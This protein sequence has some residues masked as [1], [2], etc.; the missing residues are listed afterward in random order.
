VVF[1]VHEALIDLG[2]GQFRKA[3][4]NDGINALSVLQETNDIVDTDAGSLHHGMAAPNLR[5]PCDVPIL[6]RSSNHDALMVGEVP[7]QFK[8]T[9]DSWYAPG[10]R[11]TLW[12]V[13]KTS[14]REY[15]KEFLARFP[16]SEDAFTIIGL[17]ETAV[18]CEE[19][20]PF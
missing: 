10:R 13:A 3:A 19:S 15:A 16:I 7:L 5:Q 1:V 9:P 14:L 8:L 18:T 4:G 11:S 2:S 17:D 6:L 12:F 20:H